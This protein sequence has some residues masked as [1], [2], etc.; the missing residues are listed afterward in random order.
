[1]V[2]S[3]NGE[4]GQVAT[5]VVEPE[6]WEQQEIEVATDA[7]HHL[8]RVRRLRSGDRV[9]V[10]DGRGKARWGEVV[11]IARNGA[12][13]A[14]TEAA[15]TGEPELAVDLLVAAPRPQRAGWLV[16]KATELGVRAVRFLNSERAP[17][18]YGTATLRRLRKLARSAVEQCGRSLVP[19]ISCQHP[20]VEIETIVNRL[21][22]KW[23]LQPGAPQK[24]PVARER[25]T[26][27]LGW[28]VGAEGGW[29]EREREALESYGCVPVGLGERILRVETA[30]IAAAASVLVSP[31]V[32]T[33]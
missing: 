30:A 10:V 21:D 8:F 18:R 26:G 1:M 23:I 4:I 25:L 24:M 32:D 16:E 15:P 5:L 27:S 11:S 19:E 7:Y 33:P 9:R 29:S 17:R 6:E 2:R 20:W 28:L 13:L 12:R 3:R 14:L 31:F 22:C